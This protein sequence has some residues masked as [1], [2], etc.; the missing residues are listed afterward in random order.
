M[1]IKEKQLL[2]KDLSSRLSYNVKCCISN[3]KT[4]VLAAI[5]HDGENT[6]FDFWDTNQVVY[7]YQLYISEFKPYLYPL[8]SIEELGLLEEYESIVCV[9][10]NDKNTDFVFINHIEQLLEFYHKN[11]IDYRGLI[12]KGLAIDCTGLDIY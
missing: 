8:S 1:K 7:K 3:N 6:L 12:P 11:H 4:H 5:Q 10:N 2:L 9:L